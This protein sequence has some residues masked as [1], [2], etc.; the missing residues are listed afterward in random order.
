MDNKL[1][2]TLVDKK[3]K[4]CFLHYRGTSCCYYLYSRV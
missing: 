4:W 2:S 1:P 3:W